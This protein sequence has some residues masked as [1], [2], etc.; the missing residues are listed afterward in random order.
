MADE[1]LN[2]YRRPTTH[3][4]YQRRHKDDYALPSIF[5]LKSNPCLYIIPRIIS[6][7]ASQ[8]MPTQEGRM[9]KGHAPRRAALFNLKARAYPFLSRARAYPTNLLTLQNNV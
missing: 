3:F 8:F 7:F 6:T 2:E 1:L 4:L 5:I 9:E